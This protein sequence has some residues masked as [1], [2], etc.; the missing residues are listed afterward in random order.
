MAETVIQPLKADP[1][2]QANDSLRGY[3]YQ[4]L[5]SVNAWL[6][7]ADNEILYLEGVEDF[8]KLSD[9]S[10]YGSTS[11]RHTTQHHTQISRK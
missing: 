4:V 3:L 11:Q 9:D 5:H 7:L 8:D 1:K 10:C 6:D 2:R